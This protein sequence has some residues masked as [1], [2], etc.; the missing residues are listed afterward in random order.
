MSD[1]TAAPPGADS[2][3][4]PGGPP[5]RPGLP[6][7][8]LLVIGAAVLA[9]VSA[10]V[11]AVIIITQ[12]RISEVALN[13]RDHLLPQILAQHD[14]S[15]NVERL[16]F[17]GEMVLNARTTV[18]RREGRLSAQVLAYDPSFRFD[19]EVEARV[20]ETYHTIVALAEQRERRD[21]L[22]LQVLRQQLEAEDALIAVAAAS[23]DATAGRDLHRLLLEVA[24]AS[25]EPA[26]RPL[27]DRFLALAAARPDPAAGTLRRVVELK[28]EVFAID[29]SNSATW[30]A[31]V[32]RL[33]QITD[34]LSVR[35][36]VQTGNRFT[37]IVKQANRADTV[38]VAGLAGFAL[39]VSA[40]VLVGHR[41]VL[42]PLTGATRILEN[43]AQ[44]GETPDLPKSPIAEVTSIVAAA[45]SLTEYTHAL[46]EERRKVVQVRLE[47]AAAREKELRVLVAQR[48]HE[49]EQ[50]KERAESANRAKSV[51]L[52][53]MSH[54]L[55]TPLNAVLG[56][57]RLMMHDANL[58]PE[59]RDHLSIISRSGEHLLQLINDVLDMSKIEAGR[60]KP[61][62]V[63]FDLKR[64][65]LD[66]SN[67]LRVRAEEKG[68]RLISEL[69][70][71]VPAHV[72]GDAGKLRQVLINL[73]GNAI[74]YTDEGGV[75]LRLGLGSEIKDGKVHLVGE[76]EDTG[77]GIPAAD[78]KR[79]F[80][81]FEQV[82]SFDQNK[83]TGLGLAITREFLELMGGTLSVQSEHG[84]GSVFR[85]AL[86]LER[87][88]EATAN[89]ARMLPRR[90]I[91][92]VPGQPDYRILIVEDNP[93]N[94]LL[95]RRQLEG[96]GFTVR[97]AADGA[98][99]VR[100][101]AEWRPHFIWMDRRMPVMDGLEATRTI[102]EMDGGRETAIVAI[103]A[104][105]FTEQAQELR[106]GGCDDFV[107]KPY[108]EEE[109]FAALERH[110][111][112]KF[113]YAEPDAMPDP[114][115]E[116]GELS[117][118]ALRRLP[119]ELVE[120]LHRCV[121]QRA[122][123]A[124]GKLADRVALH[125]PALAN[126]IRGLLSRFDWKTLGAFLGDNLAMDA[127]QQGGAGQ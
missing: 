95:L 18:K 37:E 71:E 27:A 17:F 109:I 122:V 107:R 91:G 126:A 89:P 70:P 78:L 33:K 24:H 127:A 106:E 81:P 19:P 99:G 98:E 30:D 76:V 115:A 58:R 75:A 10:A 66:V 117:A 65:V 84:M 48:T 41:F 73:L 68:L 69:G 11:F 100:V 62:P 45:K 124:T 47:A 50:A 110:L 83:G 57:S 32:Q 16:L 54:E 36:A 23:G 59:H 34:A 43:A 116:K 15:R 72:R 113:R 105:A 82:S 2:H 7:R 55:R 51:F 44:G 104:S 20:K 25:D 94:R 38:A 120:E 123:S 31:A 103:T 111:G 14:T 114:A 9:A 4:V 12:S 1:A 39:L 121:T 93:E 118:E 22:A 79:I 92:L 90:V 29:R 108:R 3:G 96:V 87:V 53:N 63:N 64:M 46:D 61:E 67:M 97:D 21:A 60:M 56:F 6:L 88:D 28:R 102:R 86:P 5:N 42:R 13:T 8:R 119:P 77:V 101:F 26:L 52:A 112:V 85:F 74:K 125:E 35:A 80:E 40:L 49:L